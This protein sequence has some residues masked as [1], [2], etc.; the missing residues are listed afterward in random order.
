M[1]W[2]EMR[3]SMKIKDKED[4]EMKVPQWRYEDQPKSA[5]CIE[6]EKI[7]TSKM[8][9]NFDFDPKNGS[10]TSKSE[11]IVK[12]SSKGYRCDDKIA[13]FD[14]R[15][16]R[17]IWYDKQEVENMIKRKR[18]MSAVEWEV[19]ERWQQTSLHIQYAIIR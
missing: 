15:K 19:H 6:E 14:G 7:W 17:I 3:N 11:K 2:D 4:E 10:R 1:E 12:I 13:H 9:P 5:N 18:K 16:R 8:N